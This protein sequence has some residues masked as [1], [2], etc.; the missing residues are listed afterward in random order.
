MAAFKAVTRLWASLWTA[1][2][3]LAAKSLIL[4]RLA[5]RNATASATVVADPTPAKMAAS[6]AQNT[7]PLPA[8]K[9][10]GSGL[11]SACT[12]QKV[13][14]AALFAASEGLPEALASFEA[15]AARAAVTRLW[16]SARMLSLGMLLAKPSIAALF[17]LRKV[18]RSAVE[19]T[20]DNSLSSVML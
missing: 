14:M 5:L 16:A 15:T 4:A 8:A 11:P 3:I 17:A 2:G 13:S 6:S 19:L 9:F 20:L 7:V 18:K 12:P 10:A 1:L